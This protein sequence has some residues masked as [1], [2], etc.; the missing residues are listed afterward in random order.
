MGNEGVA[1]AAASGFRTLA[2][3]TSEDKDEADNDA[4]MSA[5]WGFGVGAMSAILP[6]LH[7]SGADDTLSLEDADQ[8]PKAKKRRTSGS[9]STILGL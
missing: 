4:L 9:S 1:E 6:T 3:T 2:G 7:G 8:D 5:L